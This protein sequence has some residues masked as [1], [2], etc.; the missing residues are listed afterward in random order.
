M[1]SIINEKMRKERSSI[2][3]YEQDSLNICYGGKLMRFTPIHHLQ[4]G[5]LGDRWVLMHILR[6]DYVMVVPCFKSQ[7][8]RI[9]ETPSKTH[10]HH[11]QVGSLGDAWFLTHILDIYYVLLV[12]SFKLILFRVI[13]KLN[14]K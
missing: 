11:F 7:V 4:V 12:P 5:S 10:I 6:I 3:L 2:V 9:S 8:S 14:I 1:G 13:L